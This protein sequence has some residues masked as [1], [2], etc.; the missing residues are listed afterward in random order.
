MYRQIYDSPLPAPNE[1]LDGKERNGKRRGR[2]GEGPNHKAL[3][4]RVME[5]PSLVRRGLRPEDTATEVELLSGDRVDVV[6]A[7]KDGTVAIEV[8][9]RDSDRNDLERGVYQCVKY[10]AVLAAQDIRRKPIVG[11]LA[12][13]GNSAAGRT[14]GACAPTRRPHKSDHAGVGRALVVS[15]A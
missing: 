5:E 1:R 11:E 13:D 2:G 9:S 15:Y 3:R 14:Q 7:A 6:L 10:R 4:L 8:K 12:G